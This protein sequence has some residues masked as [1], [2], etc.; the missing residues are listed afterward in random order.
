MCVAESCVCRRVSHTSPSLARVAESCVRRR[1][2][3][4]SPSLVCVA[5]SHTQSS[6]SLVCVAESRARR[7]V[8][9]A[10]PSL[11]RVAESRAP[12]YTYLPASHRTLPA[13]LGGQHISHGPP[14][15]LRT[16]VTFCVTFGAEFDDLFMLPPCQCKSRSSEGEQDRARQISKADESRPYMAG[17][18]KTHRASQRGF[19]SQ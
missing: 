7:R 18:G 14:G 4:A 1:V 6:P 5:E 10:S 19:A 16:H 9:R 12:T 2:S 13:Y 3:R 17:P 15:S 8:S 11:A